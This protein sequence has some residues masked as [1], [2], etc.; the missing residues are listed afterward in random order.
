MSWG[1]V[2]FLKKYIDGKKVFVASDTVIKNGDTIIPKLN[3]TLSAI[4]TTYKSS[5]SGSSSI[6]IDIYENGE[7]IKEAGITLTEQGTLVTNI[8]FNVISGREYEIDYSSS[9]IKDVSIGGQ[10]IDYN[11]YE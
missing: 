2:L 9:L 1:Q 6:S 3:G 10:I 4:I 5:S 11:Y 8:P 7:I